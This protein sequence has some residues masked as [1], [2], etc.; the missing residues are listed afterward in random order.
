[1]QLDRSNI[2]HFSPVKILSTLLL[3]VCTTL[4]RGNETAPCVLILGDS[5]SAA[6]GIKHNQ[7]WVSLLDQQLKQS[8]DHYQIVNASISG[9]TTGGGLN[10]LPALLKK[11]KPDIVFL[12]LGANDGLRGFPIT[13]IQKNLKQ[14]ITLS[15]QANA[16]V[17][18]AGMHLPPN[19]GARYTRLFHENFALLA[20]Q[21]NIPLIPFFLEGVAGN[22][23]LIQ[24]DGLHPTAQAQPL[25]LQNVMPYLKKILS[26]TN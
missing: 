3:I 24:A 19:Y 6:Y 8:A 5:L 10:R 13:T 22:T 2:N 17:L 15:Q 23:Q 14:I 21:F 20:Q 9:E 7:G 11:H 18:L 26:I 12:E 25:I 1:M 4:C 16:K